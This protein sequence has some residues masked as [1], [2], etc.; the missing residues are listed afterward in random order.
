MKNERQRSTAIG[1]LLAAFALLWLFGNVEL[2]FAGSVCTC[3]GEDC[4]DYYD[5]QIQKY[6]TGS[7]SINWSY[8]YYAKLNSGT[9]STY[10]YDL[11]IPHYYSSCATV[12]LEAVP[13]DNSYLSDLNGSSS[14]TTSWLMTSTAVATVTFKTAYTLTVTTAGTGSGSVSDSSSLLTWNGSAG[15]YTHYAPNTSVKLTA[16][17][18]SDSY[19]AGWSGGGC[20]GTSSTC[21]V[22]MS[23]A[24]SVTATFSQP[25][26]TLTVTKSGTGSGSV[27]ANTGGLTWN[28][29][30][31]TYTHYAPDTSVKLTAE[32]SSG[33]YFAGWS[34][35]GCSGTSST[36]TVTMSA[37]QSVAA[38][39]NT[40]ATLTL[41]LGSSV[42][43]I[44]T[45]TNLI[46]VSATPSETLT[47]D[48]STNTATATYPFDT[49]V[50][51]TAGDL[52]SGSFSSWSGDCSGT[53]STCTLTMSANKSVTASYTLNKYTLTVTNAGTGFGYETA[54]KSG[55]SMSSDGTL[56]SGSYSYGTSVVIYPNYY[57]SSTSSSTS[58][59]SGWSGCDST[60]TWYTGGPLTCTKAIYKN[61]KVTA[62]FDCTA[63]CVTLTVTK[64]GTA[65]SSSSV[66]ASTGTLSWSG[67]GYTGTASYAVNKSVTLTANA[68]SGTTF[69]GWTGCDSTSGSTCTV[70]MSAAQNVT[71]TFN[72]ITYPLTITTT[73][74][75]TATTV[76]VSTGT[77]SGSNP[78]TATYDTG[79]SVTIVV[80]TPTSD[81]IVS[82][83][84]GGCS[85][86]GSTCT[87]TMSQAQDVTVTISVAQTLT[88]S[89]ITEPSSTGSVG[90]STGTIS[91]SGTTTA[92]IGTAKYV[93]D[94][95][96]TLTASASS[97]SIFTGWSGSCSGT[98]STCTLT[99]SKA[100]N[101]T[102]TFNVA[103]TLTVTK[104]GS[105]SIAPDSGTLSGSNGI[106]KAYYSGG[107]S[108]TLTAYPATGYT[109]TGWTGC[110]INDSHTPTTCVVYMKSDKNVTATFSYSGYTL[111]I[112]KSP[113]AGGSVG[114]S[115]G[116]LSG[117]N[118]YTASYATGTSL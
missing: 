10:P 112:T 45:V 44:Y 65:A 51:L 8:S 27:K 97:G 3:S 48:G 73:G 77:L 29:S 83:S 47:V 75:N 105:G 41:A 81:F 1:L 16:V 56:Y 115:T 111:T 46:S 101:V 59:L 36:C 4:N 89:K 55:G 20:S 14:S 12:T 39:F 70:A 31:G 37:A 63:G 23:A 61:E 5:L 86:T 24:Q 25:A 11:W 85:G 33:S 13:D 22:T 66:T 28:G 21:T 117:S 94:T 92:L 34:G 71:A 78:Y 60:Q 96:V 87:V 69:A 95:S 108:V 54:N 57:N 76:A 100:R 114:V 116:S 67:D 58:T 102:A 19:F 74:T 103:K 40:G 110:D 38:T 53:S 88:I 99:M 93:T 26:Y 42:S 113:N 7:G 106:Y 104:V 90:V 80:T 6:G 64:D 9:I 49:V 82:W 2:G 15:T 50:K 72:T 30:A 35:G 68:A 109:F 118:P 43:S 79:T 18:A 32:A 52:G 62:T 98:D 84:G 17:P 91:W 107:T